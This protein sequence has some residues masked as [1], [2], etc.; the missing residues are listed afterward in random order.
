MS[1]ALNNFVV[2][3]GAGVTIRNTNESTNLISQI[4]T[5]VLEHDMIF[6]CIVS[7]AIFK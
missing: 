2:F 6:M 7:F 3:G 4:F 1:A 5:D